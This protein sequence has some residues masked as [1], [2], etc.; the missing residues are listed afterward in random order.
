MFDCPRHRE[1]IDAPANVSCVCSCFDRTT[2]YSG[3]S[4]LGRVTKAV[5]KACL[6]NRIKAAAF[7]VGKTGVLAVGLWVGQIDFPVCDIE[8][9]A[10][11]HGF[12]GFQAFDVGE[13]VDIPFCAVIESAGAFVLIVASANLGVYTVTRK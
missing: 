7:F 1:V 5:D 11:Y 13:E 3:R 10:E 8:I 6:Q 2:S 9:A 4:R 12:A